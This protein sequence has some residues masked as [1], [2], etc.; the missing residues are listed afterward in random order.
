[1]LQGR[2]EASIE[3]QEWVQSEKD[4]GEQIWRDFLLEER[5]KKDL[6][7]QQVVQLLSLVSLP[8]PTLPL[9]KAVSECDHAIQEQELTSIQDEKPPQPQPDEGYESEQAVFD[10]EADILGKGKSVTLGMWHNSWQKKP[11]GNGLGRNQC[12]FVPSAVH[13]NK[14]WKMVSSMVGGG[15]ELSLVPTQR[16][17]MGGPSNCDA[18]YGPEETRPFKKLEVVEFMDVRGLPYVDLELYI[19]LKTITLETGTTS[20]VQ[21]KL[22]RAARTFLKTYRT[23]HLQPEILLEIQHWTVLAAMIPTKSE[24]LGMKMMAKK[25]LFGQMG[26]AAAFKRDGKLRENKRW[27]QLFSPATTLEMYKP[28]KA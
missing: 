7:H 18:S 28:D 12:S 20:Q 24:L 3:N 27:W 17:E 6:K 14:R 10:R 9:E 13:P 22:H 19:A 1:M 26:Q 11:Y 23:D 21:A 4:Y 2:A 8:P 15:W 25:K 16:P 5:L